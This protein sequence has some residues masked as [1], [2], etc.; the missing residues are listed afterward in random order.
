MG[1]WHDRPIEPENAGMERDGS[2][3]IAWQAD[4]YAA[5]HVYARFWPRA[6]LERFAQQVAD[7][8]LTH[9]TLAELRRGLR[10]ELGGLFDIEAPDADAPDRRVRVNFHPP[11]GTP[12]PDADIGF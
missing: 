12:N 6:D 10:N 8:A 7:V 3:R 1:Q 4:G 9:R 2:I 11:V 5:I